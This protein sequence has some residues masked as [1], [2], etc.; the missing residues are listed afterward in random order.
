MLAGMGGGE[1]HSLSLRIFLCTV[2]PSFVLYNFA[3]WK[4]PCSIFSFIHLIFG[5]ML[6]TEE[7]VS[8]DFCQ[9]SRVI[10]DPV[11][12]VD[13][14]ASFSRDLDDA[15]LPTAVMAVSTGTGD[16]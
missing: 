16:L 6:P 12:D 10:S 2:S 3:G 5:M 4:S 15:N 7:G 8:Q 14:M 13:G 11:A 9:P 1:N